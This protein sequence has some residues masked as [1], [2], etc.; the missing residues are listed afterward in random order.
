MKTLTCDCC[1]YEAHEKRGIVG[2]EFEYMG[3]E[4]LWNSHRFLGVVD[5]CGS[6]RRFVKLKMMRN[7]IQENRSRENH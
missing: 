4:T 1:G 6:C 7:R 2:R 3:F 5:V